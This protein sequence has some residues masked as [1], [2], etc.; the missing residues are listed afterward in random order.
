MTI[1]SGQRT[2]MARRQRP[3]F[4]FARQNQAARLPLADLSLS[5]LTKEAGAKRLQIP[6]R[7]RGEVAQLLLKLGA[8][9][10]MQSGVN[11]VVQR[12]GDLVTQE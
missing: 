5:V 12:N 4:S 1:S 2:M 3:V 6:R 8:T 10:L 9:P 7:Y 11:I